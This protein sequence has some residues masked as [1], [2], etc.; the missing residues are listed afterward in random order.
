MQDAV[1][2]SG[3]GCFPCAL[4]GAEIQLDQRSTMPHVASGEP[5]VLSLT[6][7]PCVYVVDM[8][9]WASEPAI[10]AGS[11]WG[12]RAE[13]WPVRSIATVHGRK[14]GDVE[15]QPQQ[16][17]QRHNF[18][19][20]CSALS[21]QQYLQFKQMVILF[22]LLITFGCPLAASFVLEV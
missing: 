2:V 11:I 10:S 1:L 7:L 20:N 14:H 18:M 13:Q 4:L 6:E 21:R 8:L 9:Y 5:V 3:T 22:P 16:Q 17:L 12:G 15:A 19:L